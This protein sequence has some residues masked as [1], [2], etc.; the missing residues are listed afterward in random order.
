VVTCTGGI[1]VKL[2]R[3]TIVVS[4]VPTD[5]QT[6]AIFERSGGDLGVGGNPRTGIGYITVDRRSESLAEAVD[7][8]LQDVESVGLRPMRIVCEDDVTLQEIGDRIGRSREAVRLWAAGKKGPGGFP[9]PI[10]PGSRGTTLYSWAE[11]APWLKE[12]IGL[13]VPEAQPDLVMASRLLEAREMVPHMTPM[14][15]QRL[16]RYA[17]T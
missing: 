11:V 5:E 10:N 12:K 1:D 4:T 9:P 13:D 2:H 7:T 3:F 15:V 6:D 16:R 14:A 8:A 17:P